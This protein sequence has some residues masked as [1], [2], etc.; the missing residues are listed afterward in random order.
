MSNSTRPERTKQS[1]RRKTPADYHALAA[2]RGLA[3]LGPEVRSTKEKTGWRCRCGREWQTTYT[4]VKQGSTCTCPT[5]AHQKVSD[6]VRK[7]PADYHA[8]AAERSLVW[9]GPEV[10]NGVE[11]TG[12][13]CRC[14]CEWQTTYTTVKQGSTGT[15]PTCANQR[16]N[17]LHRNP[18]EDYHALAAER[19]LV[20][21]GPEVRSTREKTGWRCRYGHE[22]QTAYYVIQRGRTCPTCAHQR[23]HD[24]LRKTPEDYHALAAERG[25]VWLGP[26]VRSATEK[27]GWQ[28]SEI[29]QWEAVYRNIA[30]GT[31]CPDCADMVNGVRVSSPQRALCEMIDGELNRPEGD[32]YIDVAVLVDGVPVAIEYDGWFWHMDKQ[33]EDAARTAELIRR[34]WKVLRVKSGALLPEERDVALAVE[35]L[36]KG[37]DYTEIVLDDWRE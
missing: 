31:G 33:P 32:Y 5:C 20:W 8:L 12:W 6:L 18:P 27:T 14:G 1:T 34:G 10:R 3:W 28:C 11:K 15:C 29:H 24:P 35:R 2:E 22:W 25:F 21:L 13:R 16:R 36:L 17:D 9:L 19:G 23:S 37:D 26:E 7:T 4:T 30:Q